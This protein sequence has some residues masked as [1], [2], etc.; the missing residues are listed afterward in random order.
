MKGKLIFI[1]S[2]IITVYFLSLF[3]N[4]YVIEFE[5]GLF[6]FIGE[7]ITIPILIGQLFVLVISIK[8]TIEDKFSLK[9]YS[10]W[11]FILSGITSIWTFTSL[12]FGIG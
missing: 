4:A 10:F 11:A 2:L 9:T 12:I 7:L 8:Y 3:L 1:I 5:N 6:R